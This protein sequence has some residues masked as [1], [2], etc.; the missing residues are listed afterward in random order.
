[1]L[2]KLE[3]TLL[4]AAVKQAA[5]SLDAARAVDAGRQQ[6][7]PQS[8][9]V[10]QGFISRATLEQL[11]QALDA[12]KS[13]VALSRAQLERAQADVANSIIRS[14]IDGIIIKRTADLGQNGGCQLSD[15]K[16]VYH[17]PRPEADAD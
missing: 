3:P 1:M 9:L 4:N 6:L 8:R 10:D 14:P 17:R 11:R 16:P 5:A 2:L 15:A 12:A 13:Q 7:Q